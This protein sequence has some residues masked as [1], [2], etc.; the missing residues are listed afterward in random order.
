M[1][2]KRVRENRQSVSS[3]KP[4]KR[5]WAA[6]RVLCK[7]LVSFYLSSLSVMTH[8]MAALRRHHDPTNLGTLRLVPDIFSR[9]TRFFGR[10]PTKR[11]ANSHRC[12]REINEAAVS[13]TSAP[14]CLKAP[15]ANRGLKFNRSINFSCITMF[16]LLIF[17]VD[18]S[19]LKLK[20][21]DV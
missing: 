16:S 2:I 20:D 13:R 8:G 3:E 7:I 17:C 12:Y 18:F 21:E 11:A 9:S 14:G 4:P 10:K 15:N 1:E 6:S 5:T 19:G